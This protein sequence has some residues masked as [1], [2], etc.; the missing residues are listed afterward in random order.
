MLEEALSRCSHFLLDR[1]HRKLATSQQNLRVFLESAPVPR[2]PSAA[3]LSLSLLLGEGKL[4]SNALHFF[5]EGLRLPTLAKKRETQ[6]KRSKRRTSL[7]PRRQLTKLHENSFEGSTSC[8][9]F[10]KSISLYP[11]Q[12]LAL[13]RCAFPPPPG[14]VLQYL[15]CFPLQVFILTFTCG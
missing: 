9:S 4:Q 3:P 15:P 13:L 10:L 1:P 8:C 12:C 7:N 14:A 6:W 11:S 5:G 2:L